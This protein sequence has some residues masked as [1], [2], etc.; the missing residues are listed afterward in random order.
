V[1]SSVNRT[2]RVLMLRAGGDVLLHLVRDDS[3]VSLCGI[4]RAALGQPSPSVSDVVCPDCIEWLPK[5]MD[6][7]TA[8]PRIER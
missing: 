8:H 4:P 1:S 7:S 5:R 2:Y 3:E 6:F